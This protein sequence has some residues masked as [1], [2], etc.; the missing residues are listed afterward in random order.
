MILE[1]SNAVFC[2]NGTLR[3]TASCE[4]E[5]ISFCP[6][7]VRSRSSYWVPHVVEDATVPLAREQPAF[8]QVRIANELRKRELKMPTAC[9]RCAGLDSLGAGDS[10]SG[11]AECGRDTLQAWWLVVMNSVS[12]GL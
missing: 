10:V 2:V 9:M 4:R 12:V 7:N 1:V 3:M 6:P 5:D 8:D 11:K